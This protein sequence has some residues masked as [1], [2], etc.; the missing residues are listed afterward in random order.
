MGSCN[1]QNDKLL[2]KYIVGEKL[3][4]QELMYEE[5]RCVKKGSLFPIYH[6]SARNN[7]GT[8]QLIEAISNLFVLK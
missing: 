6:G 8:Q 5:Y 1:F 4:I 3:T 7:I 2:E